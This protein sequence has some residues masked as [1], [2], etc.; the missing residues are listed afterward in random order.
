MLYEYETLSVET[1]QTKDNAYLGT[2]LRVTEE[3]LFLFDNPTNEDLKHNFSKVFST[4]V[5]PF[6]EMRLWLTHET[7]EID[8]LCETFT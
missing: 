6:K 5:N 2:P 1:Y 7:L 8:S 3:S 4:V